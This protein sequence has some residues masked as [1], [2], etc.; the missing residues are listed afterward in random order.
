MSPILDTDTLLSPS[1]VAAR[2]GVHRSRIGQLIHAGQ[3]P[4]V[5]IDGY[6]FV[7]AEDVEA[8]LATLSRPR[9]GGTRRKSTPA[10]RGRVSESGTSRKRS[11]RGTAAPRRPSP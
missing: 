5:M 10:A 7:R 9:G 4:A 6:W 11:R 1:T 8:R 3:L 2:L